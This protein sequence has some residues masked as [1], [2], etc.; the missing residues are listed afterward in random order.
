MHCKRCC[1]VCDHLQNFKN[2]I[3][4]QK[5]QNHNVFQAIL[6]N[7]DFWT[8]DPPS[9]TYTTVN[10]ITPDLAWCKFGPKKIKCFYSDFCLIFFL[11]PTKTCPTRT[12]R[13]SLKCLLGLSQRVVI[14]SLSFYGKLN[15]VM[16][17]YINGKILVCFHDVHTFQWSQALLKDS[18]GY[19]LLAL[20]KFVQLL[21]KRNRMWQKVLF[22]EL[23][24]SGLFKLLCLFDGAQNW[25]AF[26]K[27]TP[28]I[29]QIGPEDS[30]DDIEQLWI[31]NVNRYIRANRNG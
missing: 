18:L 4:F 19:S 26:D 25:L 31:Q 11:L 24:H 13:L 27:M 6:D 15:I 1:L 16:W 12:R 10:Q 3:R 14:I 21:I 5:F 8:P 28:R 22:M 30:S 7:F 2:F 17:I 9:P 29:S 23:A 20:D